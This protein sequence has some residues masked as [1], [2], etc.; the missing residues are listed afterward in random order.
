MTKQE[1]WIEED[2][3]H[4]YL[5]DEAYIEEGIRREIEAE[6]QE[7]LDYQNRKPAQIIV[8]LEEKKK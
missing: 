1:N 7:Y 6:W 2:F 8:T 3:E 5:R 4:Q